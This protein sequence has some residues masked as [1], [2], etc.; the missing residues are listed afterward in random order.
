MKLHVKSGSFLQITAEHQDCPFFTVF[1]TMKP[2]SQNI[3]IM[4]L[5]V[6]L[7]LHGHRGRYWISEEK[8]PVNNFGRTVPSVE[9]YCYK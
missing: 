8:A 1:L 6:S 9:K 3:S 5:Q 2:L 4:L 7:K